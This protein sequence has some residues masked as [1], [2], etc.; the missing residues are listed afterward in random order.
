MPD[1]KTIIVKALD[2]AARSGISDSSQIADMI[3]TY[4]E[5]GLDIG[6]SSPDD[7]AQAKLANMG[8]VGLIKSPSRLEVDKLSERAQE[9]IVAI[10]FNPESRNDEPQEA[11]EC[12]RIEDLSTAV[13]R[14]MPV[15]IPIS[16]NTDVGKRDVIFTRAIKTVTKNPDPTKGAG[17]SSV[18]VAYIPP[19]Q[20][21]GPTLSFDT[22]MPPTIDWA[23]Q[24]E[25]I[26]AQA[27]ELFRKRGEINVV[28]PKQI[29]LPSDLMNADSLML[30]GRADV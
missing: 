13:S 22:L 20:T 5:I 26:E 8:R 18:H 6:L 4:L 11:L 7:Q 28:E 14:N 30:I 15:N 10:D 24:I 16:L 29:Q 1:K 27:R 12:W 21:I 2:K 19:G 25:Q 9:R 17:F 23:L 3:L